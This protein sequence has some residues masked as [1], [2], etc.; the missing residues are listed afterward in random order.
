[1]RST[2]AISKPLG[3][4][5]R[6]VHLRCDPRSKCLKQNLSVSFCNVCEAC[7]AVGFLNYA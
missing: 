3:N 6:L 7:A 1:M 2:Q 4:Y 5:K